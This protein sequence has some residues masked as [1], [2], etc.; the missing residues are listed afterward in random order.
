M[1]YCLAITV[2]KRQRK[3]ATEFKASLGHRVS[4]ASLHYRV[5]VCPWEVGRSG[6]GDT[7]GSTVGL[8]YA[9]DSILKNFNCLGCK[10]NKDLLLLL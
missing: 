9:L 2:V 3:E 1:V 8:L 5:R 7:Q 6:T 10:K 4:W